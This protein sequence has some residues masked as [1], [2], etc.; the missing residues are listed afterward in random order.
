MKITI[1]QNRFLKN[2]CLT[3]SSV[4]F[5]WSNKIDSKAYVVGDKD[6]SMSMQSSLCEL[7]AIDPPVLIPQKIQKAFS[8]LGVDS[9]S[10]PIDGVQTPN[11]MIEGVKEVFKVSRMA[12][13]S[14]ESLGYLDTFMSSNRTIKR[15]LRARIDIDCLKAAIKSGE[16]KNLSIAKGFTPKR[17]GFLELP[18]YSLTKT[19]TGRMTI[20][21]GPQI[22]TAPKFIRKYLKSSY[23]GGK[24]AQVDFISLEP[25]VAMQLTED[26]SRQ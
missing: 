19:L 12:L 21:E 6:A 18:K 24:I 20:V 3:S 5:S 23:P 25:R 13:D 10:L 11:Q 9:F 26:E 7:L 17:D 1:P 22:L 15:L 4:G 2:H 16:I 14:L 8:V